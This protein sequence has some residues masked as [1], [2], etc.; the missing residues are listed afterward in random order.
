MSKCR[1]NELEFSLNYIREPKKITRIK[2]RILNKIKAKKLTQIDIFF[3]I[4]NK[5]KKPYFIPAQKRYH[6]GKTECYLIAISP[7]LHEA[8]AITPFGIIIDHWGT[9]RKFKKEEDK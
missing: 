3:S 6:R 2:R 5:D 1:Y 4:I 9:F 7:F 8:L